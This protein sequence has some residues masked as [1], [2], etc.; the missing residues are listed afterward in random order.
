MSLYRNLI[1]SLCVATAA[2][3]TPALAKSPHRPANEIARLAWDDRPRDQDRAFRNAQ[4]GRSMPLP[5]IERRVIP[6]MGGA[7]YLG[8]EMRGGTAN[9]TI[10]LA[11][12]AIGAPLVRNPH[13]ALV[14]RLPSLDKFEP[15]VKPE[16][17]LILNTSLIDRSVEREDLEVVSLSATDLADSLGDKRM[18]NM[19]MVG[20]LLAQLPI[21]SLEDVKA[22]LA[23]HLPKDKQHLLKGNLAALEQGYAAGARSAVKPP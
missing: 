22:S 16:G 19:V 12:E 4:E 9:C 10:I 15:L 18:A 13:A 8:P 1:L 21:L 7:D 3:A 11:D 2:V 17:T 20:A 14:M 6:R 23:V 5:Q